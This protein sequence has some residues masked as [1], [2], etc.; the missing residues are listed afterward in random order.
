MPVESL[1]NFE[2]THNTS[3]SEKN[4]NPKNRSFGKIT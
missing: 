1:E 3:K 4:Q 2:I